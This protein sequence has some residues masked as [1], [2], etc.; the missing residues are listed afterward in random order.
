[1]TESE[2]TALKTNQENA[3]QWEGQL[4]VLKVLLGL[5]G[6][7]VIV[8]L[9]IVLALEIQVG[10]RNHDIKTV[11][12]SA[13]TAKTASQ[14]A[15]KAVNEAKKSIDNAIDAANAA[16]KISTPAIAQALRTIQTIE[17]QLQLLTNKAGGK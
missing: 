5:V 16:S 3:D 13:E 1:M 17:G 7:F 10:S 14:D 2:P 11:K 6:F 12:T 15:L 8:L 4:R 9:V